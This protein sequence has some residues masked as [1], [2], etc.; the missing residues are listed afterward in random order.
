MSMHFDPQ[1]AQEAIDLV[2]EITKCDTLELV[3]QLYG[4]FKQAGEGTDVVDTPM[5]SLQDMAQQYN[6]EFVVKATKI[7]DNMQSFEELSKYINSMQ[8]NDVKAQSSDVGT[9]QDGNYDAAM[10]L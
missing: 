8:G 1:K 4:A 10:H 9:I 6:E 5:R 7:L 2:K 3:Q